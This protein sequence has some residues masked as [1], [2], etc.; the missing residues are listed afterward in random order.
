[1]RPLLTDT[2]QPADWITLIGGTLYGGANHRLD[3]PLYD[4][5]LYI[6]D[7]EE[8]GIQIL[9]RTRIWESDT[10]LD[11]RHYLASGASDQEHFLFGT[12]HRLLLC[13]GNRP[14]SLTTP[15][16]YT[17]EHHGGQIGTLDT[18]A[19]THFQ[20]RGGLS[21]QWVSPIAQK[22]TQRWLADVSFYYHYRVSDVI[23][24]GQGYGLYPTLSYECML[25]R[26][27][28]DKENSMW[29][30]RVTAGFW[31]G[32]RYYVT[33]G[34][35]QFSTLTRYGDSPMGD[36]RTLFT[37]RGEIEYEFSQMFAGFSFSSYF[38]LQYKNTDFLFGL[39]L[40]GRIRSTLKGRRD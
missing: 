15:L 26:K 38:D 7:P 28:H 35:P 29:K 33:E 2:F 39:Y 32:D 27:E 17:A 4:P 14:W 30:L 31:Y 16:T 9:M 1:M 19:V 34:A 3:L 23:V 24:D 8:E 18:N 10:W 40:K 11:W 36:I 37:T 20:M 12:S 22:G 13:S 25:K 21:F 6:F 5:S